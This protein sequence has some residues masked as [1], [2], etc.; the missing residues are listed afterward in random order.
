MRTLRLLLVLA[1]FPTTSIAALTTW[2]FDSSADG[3]TS[4][5]GEAFLAY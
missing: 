2:D 3:W 1:L 4:V 5:Q